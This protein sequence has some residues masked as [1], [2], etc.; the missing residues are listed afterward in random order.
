MSR[1]YIAL[2]LPDEGV[3]VFRPECVTV[4][5]R[6][7]LGPGLKRLRRSAQE[8]GV[9]F[10]EVL[11]VTGATRSQLTHW[12][13]T[14]FPRRHTGSGHHRLFTPREIALVAEAVRACRTWGASAARSVFVDGER[15]G[16]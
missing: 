16:L 8:E 6:V 2:A 9:K 5:S 12:M 14:F 7:S 1:D 4:L 13:R 11:A 10:K 15:I 3:G